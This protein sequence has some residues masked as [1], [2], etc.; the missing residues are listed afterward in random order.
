M[1]LINLSK[2]ELETIVYC[3]EGY[4]QGNDDEELSDEIVRIC[5]KVEQL[6]EV[7][8]CNNTSNVSQTGV[9]LEDVDDSWYDEDGNIKS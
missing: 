8:E 2:E 9:E 3:L 4:L 5:T 7:C 6:S 1:P